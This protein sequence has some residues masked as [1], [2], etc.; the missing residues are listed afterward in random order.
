MLDAY[1]H[2]CAEVFMLVKHYAK[3]IYLFINVNYDCFICFSLVCFWHK[4]M[5]DLR[6]SRVSL[7]NSFV[8]FVNFPYL[9]CEFP[10]L[11]L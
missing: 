9:I 8:S 3:N 11:H 10:V 1:L 6:T 4:T 2:Q 7:A 5:A